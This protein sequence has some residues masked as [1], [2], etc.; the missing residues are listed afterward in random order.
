MI[1]ISEITMPFRCKIILK[2]YKRWLN[3]DDAVLD[4]GCG[5]GLVANYLKKYSE[6]NIIVCDIENY[7]ICDLP[8]RKISKNGRLPFPNK[9]FDTVLLNDV[10]HHLDRSRQEGLLK[11]SIRVA[12]KVLI[13]EAKPTIFGKLAD[14]LLNRLHYGEIY[15]PLT[16]RDILE[17]QILFKKLSLKFS[18]LEIRKPF[19]YPFSH[20]VFNLEKK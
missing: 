3:K 20:I 1:T 12:K 9:R 14:V 11:E 13:F 16:F 5:N 6:I 15:T 18:A 19:W 17:W 10:L 7:L 2:T 4:V 8:F